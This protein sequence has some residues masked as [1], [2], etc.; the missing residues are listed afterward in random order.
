MREKE[1]DWIKERKVHADRK[2]RVSNKPKEN[3]TKSNSLDM[4]RKAERPACLQYTM[5]YINPPSRNS[6]LWTH[7]SPSLLVT[8][9]NGIKYIRV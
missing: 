3:M 1:L 6:F 8:A 2:N 5:A 7:K 9:Q 4:N